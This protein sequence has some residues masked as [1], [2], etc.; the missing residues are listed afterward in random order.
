MLPLTCLPT[1]WT[2][3]FGSS[4]DWDETEVILFGHDLDAVFCVIRLQA[5]SDISL[6]QCYCLIE[7]SLF[8]FSVGIASE[9]WLHG[10]TD[11]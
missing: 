9:P 8:A 1:V 3:L 11:T 5:P 2:V 10:L 4:L 6:D 7:I